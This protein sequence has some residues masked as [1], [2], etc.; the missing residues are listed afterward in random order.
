MEILCAV[1][2]FP[3]KIQ[4]LGCTFIDDISLFLC[5]RYRH[6][7]GLNKSHESFTLIIK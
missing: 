7:T 4:C 2:I 1:C 6:V 3:E 5:D